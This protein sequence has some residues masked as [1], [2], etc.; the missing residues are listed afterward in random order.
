MGVDT[1]RGISGRGASTGKDLKMEGFTQSRD[2][3]SH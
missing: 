1:G 2:R 3:D